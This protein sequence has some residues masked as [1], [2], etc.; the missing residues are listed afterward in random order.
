MGRGKPRRKKIMT[1]NSTLKSLALGAIGALVASSVSVLPANAAGLADT[2]YITLKPSTG[3][4]YTVLAAAGATFSLVANEASTVNVG[5]LKFLVS[6]P[7]GVVEPTTNTTARI[8][9]QVT[10]SANSTLVSGSATLAETTFDLDVAHTIAAGSRIAFSVNGVAPTH[11][12]SN[13]ATVTPYTVNAVVAADGIFRL[14]NAASTTQS[15]AVQASA[16][17]NVKVLREPRSSTNNTYVV[18][19][20]VNSATSNETL[21]LVVTGDTSRTVEVTAWKDSNDNGKIDDNEY[22]SPTRTIKF[23]KPSEVVATVAMNPVVGDSS[24]KAKVTTVP[25]LNGNQVLRSNPD[26]IDVAFTRQG[27]AVTLFNQ[28]D[29]VTWDDDTKEFLAEVSTDVVSGTNT[30]GRNSAAASSN[31]SSWSM[32]APVDVTSGLTYTT[33]S[34]SVTFALAA[35]TPHNLNIN[36]KITFANA[37]SDI[38]GLQFAIAAIP[39]SNSFTIATSTVSTEVGTAA[40][41]DYAIT[42]Y[43]QTPKSYVSRV[44]AGTYTAQAYIASASSGVKLEVAPQAAISDT[45][46]ITTAASGSLQGKAFDAVG[47]NT[48]LVK[49]GTLTVSA[50]AIVYDEDGVAVGAGR[51][52]AVSFTGASDTFKVNGKTGTHT[53]NTDANGAVAIEVSSLRGTK[54]S[55]LTVK[56]SAEGGAAEADIDFEWKDV[57]YNLIDLAKTNGALTTDA[58]LTRTIAKGGSYSFNFA[59]TDQWFAAA[60]AASYRLMVTGNGTTEGVKTLTD[61]KASVTVTDNG[62]GTDMST[63]IKLQ[64]LTGSTWGDVSSHTLT[65]KIQSNGGVVLGAAGSS[66]YGNAVSLSVAVAAKALVEIDARTSNTEKPAYKTNAVLNGKVVNAATNVAQ[67]GAEV[68]ISGPSTILFENDQ[69]SKRGSITVLADSN[70]LF[71]VKMY[72]TTAQTDAVVTVASLGKSAT[73]KVTFTGIGVGEG[74]SLVITAPAAVEPASTLQIKA[75][76]NDTYGNGVEATAGRIKFT[77]EGPGIGFGTVPDKTD[78]TGGLTYSVLLGAGDKGTIKVTVQYDQNGDGDFVDTKDLTKTASI[79][80]GAVAPSVEQKLTVG[81]FKGY[82]AIYAKGYAGKKL[83]AKVAGKWLSVASLSDFQRVIRNTGAGYTVKVDLYIDGSLVKERDHY[84]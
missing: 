67:A 47:T 10:T 3:T 2:S 41:V 23:I 58:A 32:V 6:D 68:V 39:A 24:L 30:V 27:S 11:G 71:E 50:K 14:A 53:V 42:T 75:Q 57:T 21:E 46:E 15:S 5:N 38:N 64:K 37:G 12:I 22:V 73:A 17:A 76:L 56:L 54:D 31:N 59:V 84:N 63:V 8:G 74:T 65:T 18:D 20:G 26:I 61:G 29:T 35:G 33:A 77:Y 19:T 83:S 79:T 81:S 48:T 80:V 7:S 60:P 72:S 44:F 69:V 1:K 78:K 13:A 9:A 82:L 25:V 66:L 51:P 36:D 43:A 45:V 34:K 70:G 49:T 40:N 4:E 16:S 62:F 55:T 28:V 52:V